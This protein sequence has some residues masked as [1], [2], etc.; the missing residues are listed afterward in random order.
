MEMLQ[1]SGTRGECD[2]P[3]Q[4]CQ[5]AA[6][7][8]TVA[9]R[10]PGTEIC[11]PLEIEEGIGQSLQVS[12]GQGLDAGFLARGQGAAAAMKLAQGH[13]GGF[14]LTAFLTALLLTLSQAAPKDFLVN[15]AVGEV[16]EGDPA[17][18]ADVRN[19]AA[20]EP[21]QQD[22]GD[23]IIELVRQGRGGSLLSDGG[24]GGRKALLWQEKQPEG[25]LEGR[26]GG[27]NPFWWQLNPEHAL[28]QKFR[29][30]QGIADIEVAARTDHD[31]APMT[32]G[33][34]WRKGWF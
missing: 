5:H 1:C 20:V 18:G 27:G 30:R 28:P 11:R 31:H 6:Q 10:K 8:S 29:H 23:H 21:C 34:Q 9:V 3:G 13:G 12:Q 33:R 26:G 24:G 19:G 7:G 15:N 22:S 17:H 4:I 16:V 2:L 32:Q 25:F 14:L